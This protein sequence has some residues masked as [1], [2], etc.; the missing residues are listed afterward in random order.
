MVVQ[1]PNGAGHTPADEDRAALIEA[2]TR[3]ISEWSA[4]DFL[5]GVVAR[6]GVELDPGAI[7]MVTML[8]T[9]GPQRPS[10][11][12]RNMVTGPS[13]V[14]KIAQRLMAAGLAEKI[15]DPD[16]A[17]AHQ[18]ALTESGYQV[19]STF[20]RAGSGL[21]DDLLHGWSPT[22]R[23][24]LLRSLQK[25]ERSTMALAAQFQNKT[26][27]GSSERNTTTRNITT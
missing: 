19:A 22:E 5:T 16:D 27:S 20:V 21:V 2:L 25:L 18:F 13:N 17:R 10:L 3:I 4:P 24:E 1:M 6:E 26:S 9:Q 23:D 15:S 14:S 8:S 7:K 12:S 11:L